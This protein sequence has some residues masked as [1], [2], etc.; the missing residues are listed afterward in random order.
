MSMA[1]LWTRIL[2]PINHLAEKLADPGEVF[3][4]ST[5]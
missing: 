3:R 1:S 2:K 5:V 4:D